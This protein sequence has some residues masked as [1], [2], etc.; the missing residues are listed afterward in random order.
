MSR[1]LSGFAYRPSR[2][3]ARLVTT[4]RSP[5]CSVTSCSCR[6]GVGAV[7]REDRGELV[8]ALAEAELDAGHEVGAADRGAGDPV[9]DVELGAGVREG[10]AEV[11]M[12]GEGR[13]P[14]G[15]Q[16]GEPVG[17]ALGRTYV[18]H[19]S[20]GPT[21]DL[22][23]TVGVLPVAV[24]QDDPAALPCLE[25]EL[26]DAQA[27]RRPPRGQQLLVGQVAPDDLRRGG[28]GTTERE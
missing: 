17:E 15:Q 6:V 3:T 20:L 10:E 1:W 11:P 23:G 24:R 16:R 4:L 26:R 28:Q 13:A 5:V 18:V 7:C 27:V 9:A 12:G 21:Y 22:T 2:E 25:D 14:A 19:D 8:E